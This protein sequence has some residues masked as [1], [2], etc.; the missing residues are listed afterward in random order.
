[1]Y[2]V[3]AAVSRLPFGPKPK[4]ME[5]T[6]IASGHFVFSPVRGEKVSYEALDKAITD[7]GYEIEDAKVVVSG[8]V[9][10]EGHLETPDG[11]RFHLTASADELRGRLAEVEPGAAL[12]VRGDW[13]LRTGNDT[14]DVVE[15]LEPAAPEVDHGEDEH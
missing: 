11:Q 12:R 7:A 3:K 8:T 15:F 4:E 1:M 14:I 2:N 5:V 13:L 6:D 10:E 9:T